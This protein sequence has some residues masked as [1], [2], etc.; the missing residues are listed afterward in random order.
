M[1]SYILIFFFTVNLSTVFNFLKIE[2]KKKINERE[3][4][5]ILAQEIIS[6]EDWKL[7]SKME[8]I[9]YQKDI[10]NF[11]YGFS[12]NKVYQIKRKKPIDVYFRI[13]NL[14]LMERKK[15]AYLLLI[16]EKELALLNRNLDVLYYKEF[17][18]KI[19][20]YFLE[21]RDFDNEDE[22]YLIF[23]NKIFYFSL[24]EEAFWQLENNWQ[25]PKWIVGDK[26]SLFLLFSD[27]IVIL[28]KESKPKKIYPK[29][30]EK[31]ILLVLKKEGLI[32]FSKIENRSVVAYEK[33]KKIEIFGDFENVD[34][35]VF[36]D[37]FLIRADNNLFFINR[38]LSYYEKVNENY[39]IKEIKD[40]KILDLNGDKREDIV[41]SNSNY[42][43]YFL[44][45]SLI[46]EES[47]KNYYQKLINRIKMEN[48]Y[49]YQ[50]LLITLLNLTAQVGIPF[51][52]IEKKIERMVKKYY[53]AKTQQQLLLSSFLSVLL[54][55]FI[56]LFVRPIFLKIKNKKWRVENRSL[57]QLIRIVEDFIAL[58]HNYLIKG[59]FLGAQKQIKKI[60]ENFKLVEEEL[61]YLRET[62]EPKF[63]VENYLSLLKK[64]LNNKNI[65][66]L[67][68]FLKEINENLEKKMEFQRINSFEINEYLKKDGYYL[69]Q[70]EDPFMGEENFNYKIFLDNKIGNFLTHLIIDHLKYADKKAI[71]MLEKKM[72]TDWQKKVIL[73][74]YSDGKTEIDFEKGHLAG[75]IK[76]IREIYFNYL[77][78]IKGT[79]AEEKVIL[80][81]SD[82]I[83]VVEGIIKKTKI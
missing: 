71:L 9:V 16:G 45:H 28:N 32:I 13:K 29:K 41:I 63:F 69:I 31:F 27:S 75:E 19:K 62:L 55:L 42:L 26:N 37:G 34:G 59:N 65:V 38:S 20:G 67:L 40:Y 47:Q 77:N 64:I 1:N 74:F 17:G 76:E 36:K 82:L 66:D 39:Q 23:K 35:K 30:N 7:F 15:G 51:L 73:H 8:D 6:K 70:V 72:I 21:D 52:E 14:E 56:V 80:V 3:I 81:F 11:F 79:Q 49:G 46:L 68:E 48:L 61:L 24:E 43:F 22:L 58:N 12:K 4:K 54:V 5:K 33:N 2:K 44:N 78:I 57:P 25:D 53:I 18:E 10:E 83:G 50:D 60:S